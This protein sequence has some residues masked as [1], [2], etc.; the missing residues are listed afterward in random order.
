MEKNM[1]AIAKGW[2]RKLLL[3][4]IYALGVFGI[5]ASGGSGSSGD[6]DFSC[7]LIVQAIAPALDATNDIWVGVLLKTNDGNFDSVVRLNS[8]GSEQLSFL[9]GEGGNAN[10]VRVIAIAEDGS[11][12]VYVGGDFSEGILRLNSNGTIDTGFAVGTGFNGRVAT[13]VPL[14]SGDV[15]VGGFFDD[16]NGTLVSGLVRLDSNGMLLSSTAGAGVSNVESIALATDGTFD[17]Y[18]GGLAPPGVGRWSQTLVAQTANFTP[19]FYSAFSLA[20]VP[21]L[22]LQIYV[23]GTF[24]NHIVR[25]NSFNG[26]TDGGFI[27]GAG[28]DADVLSL[29]LADAGDAAGDIYAGGAFTNY[30]GTSANGIVRLEVNG[31]RDFGFDVGSGF[32]DP[33][34]PASLSKVAILAQAVDGSLEVYVGGGFSK[35]DGVDS[36]GI[37]RLDVDGSLD[38]GFAVQISADGGTCD[39][40][41]IAN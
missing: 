20:T 37:A 36:N 34:D 3:A 29:E 31:D 22:P 6:R 16:Y 23:G 9:I 5:L 8:D 4:G 1:K 15:Y 32:T 33:G 17:L 2:W 40:K 21:L 12:D 39:N 19:A 41:S 14:A 27:V 18:S 10:T 11:N 28:F 30:Q 7:R 26:N 13:I 25:L 38:T 35:Y 24:T